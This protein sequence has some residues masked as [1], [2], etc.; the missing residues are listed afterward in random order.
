MLIMHIAFMQESVAP[1]PSVKLRRSAYCIHALTSRVVL[2][3]PEVF[4]WGGLILVAPGF[5]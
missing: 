1:L 5:R 3:L 4:V 2:L